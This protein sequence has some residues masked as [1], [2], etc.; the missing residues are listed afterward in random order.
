[1]EAGEQSEKINNYN[2]LI[3]F[4]EINIFLIDT[5]KYRLFEELYFWEKFFTQFK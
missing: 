2:L 4:L 5:R 1:M 3:Y